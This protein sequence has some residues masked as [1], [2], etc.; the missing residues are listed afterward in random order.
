MTQR[1]PFPTAEIARR[2]SVILQARAA[3][4]AAIASGEDFWFTV[5]NDT[6]KGVVELRVPTAEDMKIT[7]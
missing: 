2:D 5:R 3:L 6:G 1:P 7:Y 4:E